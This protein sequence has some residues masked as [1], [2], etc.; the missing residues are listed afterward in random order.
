MIETIGI[1]P[2]WP[3]GLPVNEHSI[4]PNILATLPKYFCEVATTDLYVVPR[5]NRF[6]WELSPGHLILVVPDGNPSLAHVRIL[7]PLGNSV[8]FPTFSTTYEDALVF[9]MFG[10]GAGAYRIM[11]TNGI[12]SVF[13]YWSV[14][15]PI[16]EETVEAFRRQRVR[17]ENREVDGALD[18]FFK[19]RLFPRVEEG[20][21]IKRKDKK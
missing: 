6:Q 15:H 20:R 13:P 7:S 14:A 18:K 16:Y 3:L 8:M 11:Q 12:H 4:P 2:V 21:L 9:V 5:D 17:S 10:Y 1:Q 19:Q